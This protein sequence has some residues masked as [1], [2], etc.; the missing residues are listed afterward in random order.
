ME[1][2]LRKPCSSCGSSTGSIKTKNGQDVVRCECGRFQ[3]NAPKTETGRKPR[4]VSSVHEAIKPKQRMRIIQRASGRCEL[5]FADCTQC[6]IH[7][8]HMISVASGIERGMTEQEINDD[9]NLCA[10]CDRCNLGLGD[11]PFS[12]RLAVN[13]VLSRIKYREKAV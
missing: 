5:Q 8:G 10:M 11:E 9:E 7:V 2:T 6:N 12:L 1:H 3:Y 4:T 13:I